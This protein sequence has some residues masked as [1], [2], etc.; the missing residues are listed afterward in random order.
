MRKAHGRQLYSYEELYV[1]RGGRWEIYPTGQRWLRLGT[2]LLPLAPSEVEPPITGLPTSWAVVSNLLGTD[3][4]VEPLE[5]TWARF[6]PGIPRNR[7]YGLPVPS[8]EGFWR[9]YAEPVEDFVQAALLFRDTVAAVRSRDTYQ[10]EIALDRLNALLSPIAPSLALPGHTEAVVKYSAPSLL[11][12]FAMMATLDLTG[13]RRPLHCRVCGALF[14][15]SAWG[16]QYCSQ[17]CRWTSQKRRHR[18]KKA[19]EAGSRRR[20]GSPRSHRTAHPVRDS[21]LVE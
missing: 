12:T 4:R 7:R 18:K 21:K 15:S 3:A 10:R 2:D 8:F 14:L 20:T 16:A 1:R 11:A 19:R 6:F 9:L 17:A 5:K 13:G